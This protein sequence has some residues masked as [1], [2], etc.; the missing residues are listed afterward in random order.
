[1]ARAWFEKIE[2]IQNDAIKPGPTHRGIHRCAIH[3]ANDKS[4]MRLDGNLEKGLARSASFDRLMAGTR[5][6]CIMMK[7]SGHEP[8]EIVLDRHC[9]RDVDGH[10]RGPR[11]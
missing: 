1:M 3:F 4:G 9:W 2:E 7:E 8:A 11:Q 5:I 10:L 6:C